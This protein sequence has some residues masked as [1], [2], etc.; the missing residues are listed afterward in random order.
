MITDPPYGVGYDPGWRGRRNLNRGK[1]ARGE[2]LN[3][4]RSDWREVYAQGTS[5]SLPL[6]WLMRNRPVEP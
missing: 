4:D 1:L 3:D 2:L 5:G 6:V